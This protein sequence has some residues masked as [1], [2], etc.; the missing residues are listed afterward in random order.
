MSIL[1][2]KTWTAVKKRLEEIIIFP[3]PSIVC[4]GQDHPSVIS[5]FV[6][7]HHRWCIFWL[8][9]DD[10]DFCKEVK[11]LYRDN[12]YSVAYKRNTET[13]RHFTLNYIIAIKTK[14]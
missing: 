5:D 9:Q 14:S 8:P 10:A 4:T 3:I 1:K 12:V 13:L 7:P 11:H 2:I 6:T